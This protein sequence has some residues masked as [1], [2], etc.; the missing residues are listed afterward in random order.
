MAQFVTELKEAC[1]SP[2]V[3]RERMN[4]LKG[5]EPAYGVKYE[6]LADLYEQY[7]AQLRKRGLRDSQDALGIY[8]ARK[9]K[10][11]APFMPG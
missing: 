4:V 1:L 10:K 9:T 5:F 11:T 8:R 7:E 3:F 2:E 6:A